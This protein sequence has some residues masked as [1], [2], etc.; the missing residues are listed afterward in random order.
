MCDNIDNLAD[1]ILSEIKPDIKRQI[2]HDLI[3]MQNLKKMSS[4][5]Q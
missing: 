3:C 2:P 4:Q 5:K 1:A